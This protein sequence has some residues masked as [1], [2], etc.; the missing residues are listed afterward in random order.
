MKFPSFEDLANV[1]RDSARLKRELRI[2]PD[3]K[4]CRDL[5][6]S[7]SDGAK[8]LKAIEG[9]YGIE[10]KSEPYDRIESDCSILRED[11]DDS[12]VIQTPLGGSFSEE[13]PFTVGQLYRVLLQELGALPDNPEVR[14][15][16]N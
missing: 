1:I 6:I 2:D 15:R 11:R 12:P 5:G 9:H 8:L 3:T 4:V 7:G 16:A 14:S 10:F 13:N